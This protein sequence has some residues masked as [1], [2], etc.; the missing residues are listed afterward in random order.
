MKMVNIYKQV[1]EK[2]KRKENLLNQILSVV[3]SIVNYLGYDMSG[4]FFFFLCVRACIFWLLCS[5]LYRGTS[6]YQDIALL[7]TKHF[8]KVCVY[9]FF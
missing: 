1:D 5:I 3:L 6:E 9:H 4:I 7:D 8:G 2:I